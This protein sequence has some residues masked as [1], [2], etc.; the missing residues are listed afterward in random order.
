MVCRTVQRELDNI[1]NTNSDRAPRARRVLNEIRDM[2]L[3]NRDYTIV[4][5]SK[6]IVKLCIYRQSHASP[7]LKDSLD[8]SKSD[9]ELVGYAH[10]YSQ[11]HDTDVTVL[12]HDT[13]PMMS[14]SSIGLGCTSVPD[15]WLIGSQQDSK[16]T[17]VA[18]LRARIRE[19]ERR[20]PQIKLEFVGSRHNADEAIEIDYP[21][22]EPIS[23]SQ[24]DRHLAEIADISPVQ[25][26]FGLHPKEDSAI[27]LLPKAGGLQP[28]IPPTNDEIIQY[29]DV[30]YPRWLNEC[31]SYLSNLHLMLQA[32][33]S[34]PCF[35]LAASNLGSVPAHDVLITF[36][37]HGQFQLR[38]EPYSDA[39]KIDCESD[40]NEDLP[41]PPKA[42]EGR[43]TG[44][45]DHISGLTDLFTSPTHDI[46]SL[47]AQLPDSSLHTAYIH[48][49]GTDPNSFYYKPGRP[50]EPTDSFSLECKQWRHRTEKELFRGLICVDLDNL[51][52][53][54]TIVCEVH[55]ENLSRPVRAHLRVHLRA[56][57]VN[58]NAIWDELLNR[59]KESIQQT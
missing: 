30:D 50:I 18:S 35:Q 8:Y 57:R 3:E 31:E 54:G 53:D 10:R 9:D 32:R 52:L 46:S 48:P 6:P 5:S 25:A 56:N 16:T 51:D 43:W 59:F 28:Y 41:K 15:Q 2:I 44:S 22:Y 34:P 40:P 12:T 49:Q 24:I 23:P 33:Q 38:V 4:N 45:F 14:A 20:E 47:V 13:G 11:E 7:E 1:K 37:A 36:A 26:E 21:L 42:P 27:F 39:D 55:A 19:L 58:A 29:R 17:E